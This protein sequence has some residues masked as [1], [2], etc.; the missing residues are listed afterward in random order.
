MYYILSLNLNAFYPKYYC[1]VNTDTSELLGI[2]FAYGRTD[3]TSSQ[4]KLT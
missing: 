4:L 1:E 3:S 2:K